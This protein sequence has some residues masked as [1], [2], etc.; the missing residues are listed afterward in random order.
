MSKKYDSLN[1]ELIAHILKGN[2]GV[3]K[4]DIN[5]KRDIVDDINQ[6]ICSELK[7]NGSFEISKFGT[8]QK[9]IFKAGDFKKTSVKFIPDT[10]AEK[11]IISGSAQK[12]QEFSF[13]WIFPLITLFVVLALITFAGYGIFYLS[14]TIKPS[15]P[16]IVV[17]TVEIFDQSG[18]VKL[19]D[20]VVTEKIEKI[21]YLKS[22]ETKS[23]DLMPGEGKTSEANTTEQ[24][25]E[26]LKSG[27]FS[28]ETIL[29]DGISYDRVTYVI[30]QKDT[31]WDLSGNFLRDPFLWPKIHEQNK[32]ISNPHLIEPGDKLIVLVRK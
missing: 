5:L 31:L 28:K 22:G 21:T 23:S 4:K 2:S 3:T 16:A 11:R 30:K 32:Y 25:V 17:E 10:N 19:S 26:N 9:Y 12:K 1:D 18:D 20:V 24:M 13:G 7:K 6:L 15:T 29:I 14:K 27:D 8:L